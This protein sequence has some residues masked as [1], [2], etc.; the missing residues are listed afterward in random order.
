MANR[1]V[2]GYIDLLH[3]SFYI[4]FI[5]EYS[6]S[7]VSFLNFSICFNGDKLG[8]TAVSPFSLPA[9]GLIFNPFVVASKIQRATSTYDAT[10]V[11]GDMVALERHIRNGDAADGAL[12]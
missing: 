12:I 9:D 5:I 11:G 2:L 4:W 7:L 10:S 1:E 8:E 6:N 3:I